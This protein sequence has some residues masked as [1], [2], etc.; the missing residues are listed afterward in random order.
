[1]KLSDVLN[2]FRQGKFN[3]SSH[4]KNLLEMAMV[5]GHFDNSEESLLSNIARRYNV[6]TRQLDEIRKD[7]DSIEFEVPKEKSEKFRQLFDLVHMMLIDTHVDSEEV[8]LCHIFGR[9]FGYSENKVKELVYAISK[10]IE[11]GQNVSET[12]KRV[13]WLIE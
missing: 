8:K 11:N 9:R 2:L 12:M 7:P 10:N 13:E 6:S 5:D 4:M 1:M 3:A